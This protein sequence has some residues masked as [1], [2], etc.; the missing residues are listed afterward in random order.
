[1][2]KQ[3]QLKK[4]NPKNPKNQ[5]HTTKEEVK[6]WQRQAYSYLYCQSAQAGAKLLWVRTLQASNEVCDL[7][8]ATYERK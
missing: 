3:K 2:K 8:E 4:K 7:T 5:N 1:M 6:S